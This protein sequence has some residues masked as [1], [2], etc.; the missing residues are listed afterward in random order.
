MVEQWGLQTRILTW[1]H[2]LGPAELDSDLATHW[3]VGAADPDT[4]G[5]MH[6][7]LQTQT[8]LFMHWGVGAADPDT[9][10]STGASRPGTHM[11]T[12][13]GAGPV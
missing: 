3:R 4:P 8:H 7:G 13:H 10:S 9:W 1:P 6:W 12:K 5:H 11:P 2:A